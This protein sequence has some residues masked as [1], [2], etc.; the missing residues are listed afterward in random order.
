M[1]AEHLRTVIV[2]LILGE[3]Q[4]DLQHHLNVVESFLQTYANNQNDLDARN[5]LYLSIGNA[6]DS[7]HEFDISLSAGTRKALPDIKA[8]LFFSQSSLDIAERMLDENPNAP[9]VVSNFF[10]NFNS[11]RRIYLQTLQDLEIRLALVGVEIAP[12]VEGE[13]EI[14]VTIPRAI[15]SNTID[16]LHRELATLSR[17]IK[18]YSEAVVG[19]VEIAQVREISTSDPTFFLSGIDPETIKAI[20]ASVKW[21]I[22]TLKQIVGIRKTLEELRAYNVKKAHLDPIETD[23]G[24]MVERAVESE[25]KRILDQRDHE[26]HRARELNAG[27]QW[28]LESLLAR[29]DRGMTVELRLLPPARR[30]DVAPEE[31]SPQEATLAEL[32]LLSRELSYPTPSEDSILSIP[33]P[34]PDLP[35]AGGDNSTG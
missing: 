6:R 21:A 5:S 3:N 18:F 29:V 2:E 4:Y 33:P 10:Q 9:V 15:F 19:R 7:F 34:A 30:E 32:D 35:D 16:G 27:L 22:D 14:G 20:G 31:V 25:V 24:G 13:V 12:K 11:E 28:A 1:N 26:E 23:I 8:G 17:I